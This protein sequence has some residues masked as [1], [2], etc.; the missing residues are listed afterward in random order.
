MAF[1]SQKLRISCADATKFNSPWGGEA[2]CQERKSLSLGENIYTSTTEGYRLTYLILDLP[3]KGQSANGGQAPIGAT[4]YANGRFQPQ[5]KQ[6]MLYIT[7]PEGQRVRGAQVIFSLIEPQGHHQ[8][9]RLDPWGGGYFGTIKLSG[10]G[11]FRIETELISDCQMLTDAF[12]LMVDCTAD[13][14]SQG[15]VL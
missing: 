7:D 10:F 15:I 2:G 9:A 8:M 13:P 5:S 1:D 12:W 6:L 3:G 4:R 11:T 14:W